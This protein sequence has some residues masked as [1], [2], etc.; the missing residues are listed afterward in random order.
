M[1]EEDIKLKF[2]KETVKYLLAAFG[3]VAGLA[4][5]DAVKSFIEFVFPLS[6]S[7]V[8]VKFIYAV[9]VTFL[10]FLVGQYVLKLSD[11]K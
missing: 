2:K 5:N 10:V 8:W 3:L 4:W 11:K 9:L 1:K 7:S 6:K